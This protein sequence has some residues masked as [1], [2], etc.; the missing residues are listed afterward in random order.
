MILS[1]RRCTQCKHICNERRRGGVCVALGGPID[2]LKNNSDAIKARSRY[3]RIRK[4]KNTY[5]CDVCLN[6][7]CLEAH[8]I[9]P[10]SAGGTNDESNFS[11]LCV[12]H[13]KLAHK[14]FTKNRNLDWEH[15][16]KIEHFIQDMVD[17]EANVYDKNKYNILIK[18]QLTKRLSLI[19]IRNKHN[20]FKG[21]E[22]K[23]IPNMLA[24]LHPDEIV[25]DEFADF[26]ERQKGDNS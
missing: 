11:L 13:H 1:N 2:F 16:R 9:Q 15:A 20:E 19:K 6:D 26:Y 12:K 4:E 21:K 10:L 5:F 14:T 3:H 23:T 18:K 17:A 7:E 22:V 25:V 8:H 24:E